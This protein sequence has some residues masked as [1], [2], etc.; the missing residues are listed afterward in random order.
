LGRVALL[1]IAQRQIRIKYAQKSR[2]SPMTRQ[3]LP[4]VIQTVS[5]WIH[6]KRRERNMTAC[7]LA[8]KMGIAAALIHSWESGTSQPDSQQLKVL[9]NRLGFDAPDLSRT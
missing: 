9:A 4:T 8:I 2:K 1:G 3:P 5:D 6:V 7:H